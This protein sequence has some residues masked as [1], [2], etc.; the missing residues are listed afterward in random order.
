VNTRQ[1]TTG[2]Q[3]PTPKPQQNPPDTLPQ[4]PEKIT[5]SATRRCK[6]FQRNRDES[7]RIGT[8]RDKFP[9]PRPDFE[10]RTL[11]VKRPKRQRSIPLILRVWRAGFSTVFRRQVFNFLP[12]TV[13]HSHEYSLS[14]SIGSYL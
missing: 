6:I 2:N 3:N 10:Y 14:S 9:T 12:T 13:K 7:G 5:A 4:I 1:H 8:N 11:L